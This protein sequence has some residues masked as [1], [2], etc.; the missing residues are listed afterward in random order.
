MRRSIADTLEAYLKELGN[1]GV[2]IFM[3]CFSLWFYPY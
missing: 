3:F 2:A 1:H